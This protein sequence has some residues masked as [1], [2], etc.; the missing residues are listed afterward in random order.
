MILN[1]RGTSGSGKSSVAY[2]ILN[3]FPHKIVDLGLTKKPPSGYLVSITKQRPLFI[4]GP[5]ST[6]CGGCD[7][8]PSGMEEVEAMIEK[9]HVRHHVF[10]EGLLMSGYYGNFGRWSERYGNDFIFAFLNTPLEVC[11]DRVA[12]RRKARG[13]TRPLNPTNTVT[14]FNTVWGLYDRMRLP[15]HESTARQKIHDQARRCEVID[16]RCPTDQVLSLLTNGKIG[17]DNGRHL[18]PYLEKKPI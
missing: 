1:L 5:Y 15:P 9:Y 4:V 6:P 16:Y 17:R 8:L 7:A 14:R 13:D 11:L 18:R 12:A 10:L 3:K 2:E